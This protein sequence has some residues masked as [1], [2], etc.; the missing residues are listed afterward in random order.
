MDAAGTKPPRPART[1]RGEQEETER[2]RPLEAA[3]QARAGGQGQ[4]IGVGP[5]ATVSGIQ[6][7]DGVAMEFVPSQDK[8]HQEATEGS[9]DPR[10]RRYTSTLH[11]HPTTHGKDRPV[12]PDISVGQGGS[13]AYRDSTHQHWMPVP[14]TPAVVK[15]RLG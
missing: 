5:R 4:G 10:T 6:D 12:V 3:L 8:L 1:R 7:G 2:D 11:I 15:H 14:L 13:R 9:A